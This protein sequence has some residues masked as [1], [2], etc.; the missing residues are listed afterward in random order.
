M[1]TQITCVLLTWNKLGKKCLMKTEIKIYLH[2][3]KKKK[4]SPHKIHYN[5]KKSRQKYHFGHYILVA[6]YY[7][8]FAINFC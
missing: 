2:A 1:S 5:L 4:L 8:Q 7:I 6:V 3:K